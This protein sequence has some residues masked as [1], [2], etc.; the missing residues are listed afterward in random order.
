MGLKDPNKPF[1]AGQLG[2]PLGLGL[3]KWRMQSAQESVVPLSSKSTFLAQS[4]T[5]IYGILV[6]LYASEHSWLIMSQAYGRMGLQH[7]IL[8]FT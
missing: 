4:F 5:Q 2:D 8:L 1:P 7:C 3:L 6:V